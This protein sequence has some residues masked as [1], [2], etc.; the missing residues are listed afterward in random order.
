MFLMPH[1]FI[2]QGGSFCCCFKS[3][4]TFPRN[5]QSGFAI[6]EHLDTVEVK[7]FGDDSLIGMKIPRTYDY[8]CLTLTE[9]LDLTCMDTNKVFFCI[10]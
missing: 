5:V 3:G 9:K 1:I 6:F 10:L 8:Y 4:Q 2:F 7:R